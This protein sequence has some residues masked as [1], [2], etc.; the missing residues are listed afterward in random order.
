MS[1]KSFLK[2]LG[3]DKAEGEL[4][5]TVFYSL[6]T[7]FIVLGITYWFVGRGIENFSSKFG[8]FLFLSALSYA[9]IVASTKHVRAYGNFACMSGM[10]I[11]MTS[12]MMGFLPGFFVASTNGMFYGGFFGVAVGIVLGVWNGK[13]CGTMGVLEGI[14]AGFMG[15]LMGAM[16]SFMLLNDHLLA[17]SILVF[18]I[19]AVI[20]TGLSYMIYF[21]T[22]ETERQRKEGHRFTIILTLLLMALTT[23]IMLWGPKGGIFA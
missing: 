22:K 9:F 15:G 10:M 19:S 11:G 17:A 5:G 13:C 7:S 6:V 23:Y 20:L 21:E 2:E 3:G 14:M 18:L 8:I 1:F 12:G 4:I 16:T